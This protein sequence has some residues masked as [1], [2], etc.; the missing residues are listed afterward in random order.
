[1]APSVGAAMSAM[2]AGQVQNLQLSLIRRAFVGGTVPG[3][4][5]KEA[6]STIPIV[7]ATMGDPIAT[8][9][10]ASL[11]R[12]GGNVTGLS[13]QQA[14]LGSKRLEILREL[15]PGLR[16]IATLAHA[17]APNAVNEL[18]QISVL[19]N[20]LDLQL[21]FHEIRRAEDIAPAFDTFKDRAQALY[22]VS[23]PLMA[24]Q[25]ARVGFLAL[26][27]RLPTVHGFRSYVQ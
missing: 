25:R 14:D 26:G 8:G 18:R 13:V 7:V 24:I 10:I 15:V 3:L 11:A 20:A 4:T 19:A 21:S 27:A 22:V 17:A 5:L 6:T 23:D 9:M 1:M 16:R 2:A 12:P